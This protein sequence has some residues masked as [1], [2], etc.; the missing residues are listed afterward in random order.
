MQNARPRAIAFKAC[1]NH[2]CCFCGVICVRPW[3]VLSASNFC[4]KGVQF[5]VVTLNCDSGY[6]CDNLHPAVTRACAEG[7]PITEGFSQCGSCLQSSLE[8]PHRVPPMERLGPDFRTGMDGLIIPGTAMANS[9]NTDSVFRFCI[10]SYPVLPLQI[11]NLWN[12]ALH[13]SSVVISW[14][15]TRI[16]ERCSSWEH[17][18]KHQAK[19]L[20]RADTPFMQQWKHAESV[21]I[22]VCKCS[23]SQLMYVPRCFL[24]LVDFFSACDG[25]KPMKNS[26]SSSRNSTVCLQ[27][28]TV[29]CV[30]QSPITYRTYL[31]PDTK[32]Y[33]RNL[34]N[35]SK[36]CHKNAIAYLKGCPKHPQ[37]NTSKKQV[38]NIPKWTTLMHTPHLA[39]ARFALAAT[40]AS[41]S[42]SQGI[43]FPVTNTE[44]PWKSHEEFSHFTFEIPGGFVPNRKNHKD[45]YLSPLI[46]KFSQCVSPTRFAGERSV[47][48][49]P[50]WNM[51]QNM[52]AVVTTRTHLRASLGIYFGHRCFL[53]H[54]SIA[55]ASHRR[56]DLVSSVLEIFSK[57]HRKLQT[58][59][60]H[61]VK[62]EAIGTNESGGPKLF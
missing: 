47:S 42:E 56:Q 27:P 53:L 37:T 57:K 52:A 49:T 15:D 17:R 35:D 31:H 58:N 60:H 34:M 61:L 36:K 43:T 11:L 32:E 62:R 29:I 1:R 41:A 10:L 44:A 48:E 26:G 24:G 22:D 4:W 3:K 23:Q 7:S 8:T 28:V 19:S 30:W 38:W 21:S 25:R 50:G 5:S 40:R 51:L 12:Q 54:T 2:F 16:S 18:S 6:S 20:Y 59:S 46:A 33:L 13:N 14:R 39:T 45:L 55:R 9:R